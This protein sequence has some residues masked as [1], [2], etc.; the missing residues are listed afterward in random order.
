MQIEHKNKHF[1]YTPVYWK[2]S[3]SSIV[4]IK[5]D[6]K[7]FNAIKPVLEK[8]WNQVLYCQKGNNYKKFLTDKKEYLDGSVLKLD[9]HDKCIL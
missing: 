6:R 8:E 5:R 9:L 1:K 3:D 2:V 4:R 7:W